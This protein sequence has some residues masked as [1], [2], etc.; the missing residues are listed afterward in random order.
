MKYIS[1]LAT[2]AVGALAK[3]KLLIPYYVYPFPAD[4]WQPLYTAIESNPDLIFQVVVNAGPNGARW[5][6][7]PGGNCVADQDPDH[8]CNFDWRPAVAK[9]NTYN[10]VQ[11]LGYVRTNYGNEPYDMMVNNITIWSQWKDLAGTDI[12]IHG[13]FF[14]ET[15]NNNLAHPG[16]QTDVQIMKNVT[17]VARARFSGVSNFSVVYNVGQK[18]NHDEY[19]TSGYAD[20]VIVYEGCRI[21]ETLPE[22]PPPDNNCPGYNGQAT[23]DANVPAGQAG[24]SSILVHHF[25]DGP[26]T[27]Q[28]LQALIDNIVANGIQSAFILQRTYERIWE[29]EAP[30]N[31]GAVASLFTAANAAHP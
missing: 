18:S 8:G 26:N 22:L 20:T 10:N 13:I 24:K 23:I 30:A 12:S 27:A 28:D 25:A 5:A 19:F 6:D 2:L 17:D 7:L 9:L 31:I 11:T 1:I 16:G 4:R 14:D 3:T 21:Q 15:P 29:S